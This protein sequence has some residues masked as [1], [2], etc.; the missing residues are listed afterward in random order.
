MSNKDTREYMRGYHEGQEGLPPQ[1]P[2]A[3]QIF[4]SGITPGVE[5][6]G[7]QDDYYDGRKDGKA[8][9]KR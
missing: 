1:T 8:D 9:S 6:I 2:S 4:M 3:M 7:N 5:P